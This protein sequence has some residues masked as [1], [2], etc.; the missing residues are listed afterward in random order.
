MERTDGWPSADCQ[1]AT[2]SRHL[3]S[4]IAGGMHTQVAWRTPAFAAR[5]SSRVCTRRQT[6]KTRAESGACQAPVRLGE[7]AS[8]HFPPLD[9]L[10]LPPPPS[11]LAHWQQS[12]WRL[13]STPPPQHSGGHAE[14]DEDGAPGAPWLPEPGG[15]QG[16][17]TKGNKM[18]LA[19]MLGPL[20][21]LWGSIPPRVRGLLLLNLLCMT[22]ARCAT[23]VYTFSDILCC[24]GCPR[25]ARP[26]TRSQ[27][28]EHRQRGAVQPRPLGF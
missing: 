17:G 14:P 20:L 16:R 10:A 13:Q 23:P 4:R 24:F 5:H 2:R 1:K 22:F 8:H 11:P 27:Q 28:R 26:V 6:R 9:E 7:A 15:P 25:P 3:H 18:V 12:V 21:K 19:A